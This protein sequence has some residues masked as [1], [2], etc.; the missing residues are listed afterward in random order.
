MSDHLIPR[1]IIGGRVYHKPDGKSYAYGCN[2]RAILRAKRLGCVG[3]DGDRR[4]N[5]EGHGY[6]SHN[7]NPTRNDAWFDPKGIIND[8]TPILRMSDTECDRM[9]FRFDGDL[10]PLLSDRAY[11]E[12]CKAAGIIPCVEDKTAGQSVEHWREFKRLADEIG[13][14]PVIMSLPGVGGAGERRLRT[15]HEAGLVTMWLWRPGSTV[16]DFVD[17]VKS[18]RKRPI[19]RVSKRPIAG[20]TNPPKPPETPVKSGLCPFALQKPIA[21]GAND[22]EIDPRVGILH[23]DAGNVFSLFSFFRYRS[24]GIESHFHIRKDGVIEQYRSIYRQADANRDANDFAV[25]I[26]TQGLGLGWWNP[27]Q[28]DSIKR[29]LL[30]LNEEADIPLVKITKW[31]GSGIGYHTIFGSPSHW[32]PVAKSCP[33]PNRIRQFNRKLVP[34][35]SD[36]RKGPDMTRVGEFRRDLLALLSKAQDQIP[37]N[38][39]AVHTIVRACLALARRLP[40]R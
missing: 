27:A 40:L 5:K 13:V 3:H 9:R 25:S 34:W 19:Y 30:W 39:V 20:R 10:L 35:L 31:N 15:A 36:A 6:F 37:K 22:P 17:L 4:V 32:T 26:E 11:L 16:P 24:G 38:R 8:G 2:H 18:H 29:L 28:L 14:V 12:A 7:P 1:G 33:G 23:V 21:P